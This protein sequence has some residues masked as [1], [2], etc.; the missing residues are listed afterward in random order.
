MTAPVFYMGDDY[1]VLPYHIDHQ[2]WVNPTNGEI[3]DRCITP[4]GALHW[5]VAVVACPY[6]DGCHEHQMAARVGWGY[7]RAGCSPLN[8]SRGYY[9]VVTS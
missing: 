8:D 5:V 7:Y 9:L 6:C 3:T 1:P 2:R 4:R